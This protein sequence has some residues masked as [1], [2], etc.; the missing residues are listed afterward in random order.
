MKKLIGIFFVVLSAGIDASTVEVKLDPG[1]GGFDTII[2]SYENHFSGD[3]SLTAVLISNGDKDSIVNICEPEG[4]EA[5][6]GNVATVAGGASHGDV[7]AVTCIYR[8]R[9]R[10]LGIIGDLYQVKVFESKKRKIRELTSKEKFISGFE[11]QNEDQ[12]ISFYFYKKPAFFTEKLRLLAEG[13]EIDSLPLAH[14]VAL[15]ELR[16]G[17]AEAAGIY[18][19]VELTESLFIRHPLTKENAS[20]YNDIGYILV[21]ANKMEQALSILLPIKE[22]APLRTSLYLNIADAYWSSKRDKAQRYYEKYR[23]LMIEQGRGNLVP[24]RVNERASAGK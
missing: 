3:N 2:F 24:R 15:E 16:N 20:L 11:G 22:V 17:S 18:L 8:I 10:G 7:L 21:E 4:G 6:L 14:A 12:D 13:E 23:S 9:H 5:E 1:F 19:S